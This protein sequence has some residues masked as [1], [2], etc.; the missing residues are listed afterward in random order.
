MKK[1]MGVVVA[2]MVIGVGIPMGLSF[3]KP[4]KPPEM[5]N[6]EIEQAKVMDEVALEGLNNACRAFQAQFGRYPQH[7]LEL[8]SAKY[9]P[10]LPKE[11]FSRSNRVMDHYDGLGGW[12]YDAANG[13]LLN[14]PQKQV[15]EALLA[16]TPTPG[17][18]PTPLP[19]VAEKLAPGVAAAQGLGGGPQGGAEGG[20][21]Q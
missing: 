3:A 13:F 4:K 9:Y 14:A 2:L 15:D 17:A 16:P 19:D 21:P 18:A 12:V 10:E 11:P 8:V 6:N 7:G 1:G 5:S 20:A